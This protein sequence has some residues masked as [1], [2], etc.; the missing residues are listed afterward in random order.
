MI[1]KVLFRALL[2]FVLPILVI[3][4]LFNV[5]TYLGILGILAYIAMIIVTNLTLIYCNKGRIEYAKGNLEEAAKWYKKAA[6]GKNVDANVIT[7]YGFILFKSGKVEEAE[8]IFNSVINKSKTSDEKNLAKANLALVTWKK[9]NLDEAIS[10]MKEVTK[11]YKTTSIYAS[12]GY[13]VIERGDLDEALE[14]NLEAYDY[15][16]DNAIIQD[17][18]AHLY[19]LRG[20]M[21]K[22]EELFTKLMETEPHFPEAYYD[23]GQYLEDCDKEKE[24]MEMYQK[25]LTLPFNFNST[26]SKEKVEESYERLGTRD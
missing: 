12:L 3:I 1:K 21:D 7:N 24:A 18:L 4:L 9:G 5:N 17:N 14:I 10:M 11:N 6:K 2:F 16:P 13:L 20:E 19:H 15:N 26:I 23:Y 8:K 25:A 22:A